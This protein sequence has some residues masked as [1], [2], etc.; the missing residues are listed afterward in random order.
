MAPRP[1][2]NAAP[3]SPAVLALARALARMA[4]QQDHRARTR[5]PKDRP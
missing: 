2:A 3:P 1:A 5:E 4:A